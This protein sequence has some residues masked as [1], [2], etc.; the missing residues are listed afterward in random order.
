MIP[1][2]LNMRKLFA[3]ALLLVSATSTAQENF[4]T[5]PGTLYPPACAAST[6]FENEEAQGP[7]EQISQG[8]V[9]LIDLADRQTSSVRI[10]LTRHGCSEAGRAVIK[11]QF[12]VISGGSAALPIVQAVIDDTPYVLRLT[13]D[14]NGFE[15]LN[16]GSLIFA[17][18]EYVYFLDGPTAPDREFLIDE[19]LDIL[20]VEQYNGEFDLEFIDFIDFRTYAAP[21]PAY[22]GSLE[23][24][25][26]PLNGRLSGTWINQGTSDQGFLLAFEELPDGSQILFFSWYTWHR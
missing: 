16:A 5:Y 15:E 10:T 6:Y 9:S 24:E 17:G 2:S 13:R 20:T 25:T 19:E 18:G 14:P 21:I 22:D 12:E 26:L 1:E 23:R 3:I 7:S 8:L 11:V 4:V